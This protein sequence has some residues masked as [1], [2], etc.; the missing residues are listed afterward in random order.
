MLTRKQLK[1]F[2][3]DPVPLH[4]MELDYIQSISL[5]HIY[6]KN[7][8]SVFKGGTCLRKVHSLN[9]YSEDPDFNIIAGDPEGLLKD[10]IKSLERTGIPARIVHKDDRKNV[11]LAKF[12]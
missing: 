1:N 6:A 2:N 8:S 10:G 3:P 4:V 12:K 9:R 5:R 11:F 7:R